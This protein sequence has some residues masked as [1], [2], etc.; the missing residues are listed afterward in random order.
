[1]SRTL[2]FPSDD[3]EVISRIPVT[4]LSA[5]SMGRETSRSIT[6]GDAPG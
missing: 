3:V 5:S 4:V 1:M 2:E 6:S